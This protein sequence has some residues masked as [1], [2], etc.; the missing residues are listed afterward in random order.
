M[1]KEWNINA[2]IRQV[3]AISGKR[4]YDNELV[5]IERIIN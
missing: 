3:V 1:S 5:A 2:E 4:V